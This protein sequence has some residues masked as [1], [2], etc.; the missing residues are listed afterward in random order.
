LSTTKRTPLT[1]DSGVG[2]SA[3]GAVGPASTASG[4]RRIARRVIIAFILFHLVAITCWAVPSNFLPL[5]LIRQLVRPYMLWTGLF[6]SWDMFAPDPKSANTYV[7]AIIVTQNRHILVFTF[8]R[9]ELLSLAERYRKE[10]YRKFAENLPKEQNAAV[11]PDVARHLARA[12]NNPADPPYKISLIQFHSD[13]K[14]GEDEFEAPIP[15][16]TIF[17]EDYFVQPEDLR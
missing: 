14:P 16:P 1:N 11:W 7:K 4:M 6:Q 2:S 5:I 9:M 15:E 12:Y 3:K 13:I 8:P 10:R 17:Y